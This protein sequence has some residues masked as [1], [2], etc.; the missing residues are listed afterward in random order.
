MVL[1][2]GEHKQYR[3]DP[4]KHHYPQQRLAY[5]DAVKQQIA[6]HLKRYITDREDAGRQPKHFVVQV[7]VVQELQLCKADVEPV[8]DC[9]GV[10]SEQ[11]R[12]ES[13]GHLLI[14]P[15]LIGTYQFGHCPPNLIVLR[16][17][18]NPFR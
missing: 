12:N 1:I 4:P 3:H 11:E 6:R 2:A 18:T 15:S 13:P 10:A 8:D 9:D 5:A 14:K 7:E 17:S 16:S